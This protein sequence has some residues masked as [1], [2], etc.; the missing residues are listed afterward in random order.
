M[1]RGRLLFAL[2]F[3]LLLGLAAQPASAQQ[4]RPGQLRPSPPPRAQAAKPR[5]AGPR[6]PY[7]NRPAPRRAY[8]ANAAAAQ[9]RGAARPNAEASNA[10]H[11]NA[12]ESN[13]ARTPAG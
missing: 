4:R 5:P 2:A 3:A 6:R 9:G 10:V 11:P 8:G 13:A 12:G 7:G 1:K